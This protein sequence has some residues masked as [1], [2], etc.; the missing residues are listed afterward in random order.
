[1]TELEMNQC[2]ISNFEEL[3]YVALAVENAKEAM[4]VP[5][6]REPLPKESSAFFNQVITVMKWL[7]IAM[8]LVGQIITILNP[9]KEFRGCP[10]RYSQKQAESQL[11]AL[12]LNKIQVGE[13][14][15]LV[16]S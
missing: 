3:A 13:L 8:V 6:P 1:M 5:A 10:P 15:K 2:L 9:L 7:G 11:L 4:D 14:M 12:G 16:I